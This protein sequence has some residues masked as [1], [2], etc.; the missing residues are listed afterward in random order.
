MAQPRIYVAAN[1]GRVTLRYI[2]AL[3]RAGCA[4]FC[5]EDTVSAADAFD[6]LLLP[7]GAD[8]VPARYGMAA[9]PRTCTDPALDEMQFAALNAFLPTGRPILGICRGHQLLNVAFGGTLIQHLDTAEAHGGDS[10]RFHAIRCADGSFLHRLYGTDFIVNSSHHQAIDRVGEGFV[11]AA[12]AEDG[13]IEAMAHDTGRIWAVQYH[14]ERLLFDAFP[15]AEAAGCAS[16]IPLL[17][18]FAEQC[19][20]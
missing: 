18:F 14:P 1:R 5:A 7:G 16:G 20:E 2:H 19:G 17:R 12:W 11:P 3:E 9:H 15:G 8:I 6:G 13:T 4:A 10:E